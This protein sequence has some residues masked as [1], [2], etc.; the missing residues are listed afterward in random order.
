MELDRGEASSVDLDP[1]FVGSGPD[2]RGAGRAQEMFFGQREWPAGFSPD[3]VEKVDLLAARPA[4][5][6][7]GD[8]V[9]HVQWRRC[10]G[11]Q[12]RAEYQGLPWAELGAFEA[13]GRYV[14]GCVA[15]VAEELVGG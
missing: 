1:D 6:G 5:R 10:P 7:R 15:G 4:L 8:H 13:D 11:G 2:R 9:R 12:V 3:P 14:D